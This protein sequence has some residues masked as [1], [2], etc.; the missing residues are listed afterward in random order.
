MSQEN[1]ASKLPKCVV[2]EGE[3]PDKLEVIIIGEKTAKHYE[4]DYNNEKDWTLEVDGVEYS[5]PKDGVL[6]GKK[7]LFDRC[8]ERYV[9]LYKEGEKT[10]LT[11]KVDEPPLHLSSRIFYIAL[12]SETLGKGLSSIFRGAFTLPLNA[13]T[14]TFLI[15]FLGVLGGLAWM[16]M[17]GV[18]T[19]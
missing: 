11:L 14:I 2:C 3:L 6:K 13:R 19:L 5:L 4:F 1:S 9:A 15:I 10:P 17:S 12:R 7:K 16:L 8:R 18:V